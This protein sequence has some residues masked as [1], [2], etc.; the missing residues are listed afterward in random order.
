MPDG[1][2]AR[3]TTAEGLVELEDELTAP[4]TGAVG[5]Y[6]EGLVA[7]A[8]RLPAAEVPAGYPAAVDTEEALRVDV[9]VGPETVSTFIPWP[10]DGVEGSRL[11][12]LLAA[13]EYDPGQFADLYGDRVGLT[14]RDGWHRIDLERTRKLAIRPDH[15]PQGSRT[16]AYYAVGAVTALS[17]LPTVLFSVANPDSSRLLSLVASGTFLATWLALPAAIYLDAR[18]VEGSDG[19]RPRIPVW[20]AASLVPLVRTGVGLVYLLRRRSTVAEWPAPWSWFRLVVAA[21]GLLVVAAIGL[22]A[23]PDEAFWIL[24]V[25]ATAWVLAAGSV[26]YDVR[27]VEEATDWDPLATLWVGGTV[28]SLLYAFLWLPVYLLWRWVNTR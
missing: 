16:W 13:L 3:E 11:G 23:L 17:V 6:D 20:V 21:E 25:Y 28:V 24:T 10:A 2:D 27:Y 14:T 18:T 15:S 8:T 5:A 26:C 22:V 4:E 19:W 9:D 7:G 1:D 12:R